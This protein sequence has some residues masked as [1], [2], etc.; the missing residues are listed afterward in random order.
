MMQ[1]TLIK[2]DSKMSERQRGDY[3]IRVERL[4]RGLDIKYS[5]K[6]YQALDNEI[7]RFVKDMLVVGPQQALG[8][9]NT[10]LWND[11]MMALL[12]E[13][14]RECGAIFGNASYRATRQ[15]VS[16]ST[17]PYGLDSSFIDGILQF[18]TDYGF[19]IVTL[20]TNTTK[21]RLSLLVMTLIGEGKD[22]YEIAEAILNDKELEMM[23]R[24]GGMISRTE[25]MRASNYSLY[26]ASDKHSFEVDKIWVA[27]RDTRT[28]RIPKDFFD[29]LDMDGQIRPLNEPFMSKDKLGRV[30]LADM[31][32]D[33][34]TPIGFT[35]NCRCTIMF[36]PRRDKDNNIIYK[37]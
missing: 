6:I 37:I 32:G 23:K 16:K 7:N 15:M 19:W 27:R 28:R 30:I 33:P 11:E 3:W 31:P 12:N 10:Y 4:R 26:L 25:I 22:E 14:Y 24:R 2:K 9:L 29:H 21:K 36:V 8:R 1:G 13:M 5:K 20:I 34:K 18:L 17:D 35:I